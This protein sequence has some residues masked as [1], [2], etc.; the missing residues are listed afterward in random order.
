MPTQKYFKDIKT[1][2]CFL[3][4]TGLIHSTTDRFFA[5][6]IIKCCEPHKLYRAIHK[7][8]DR[9]NYREEI[10]WSNLN[11]KIRF[12]VACELF[13]IFLTESAIFNCIILDK[14]ELDF[15]THFNDDLCKAYRSFSV[16]LLK[17]IIGKNPQEVLIVL[18]D[19]YFTPDTVSLEETIK[20][21]VNDHYQNFVV[22]GVCQI[23]STSSDLLQLTDLILGALLYD[24]KRTRGLV[25]KQ[26][27][28]K[29]KFLNFLYQKLAVTNS[30]FLKDGQEI[31]NYHSSDN[32]VQATI[33][34][35][36]RSKAHN[37][38][39]AMTHNG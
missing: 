21:F 22:A 32:K 26:N 30:F 7:L 25:N 19:N 9:Y 10:K 35:S 37:K 3:D 34:D 29:R 12:K 27:N 18:A 2:F 17:L 4:E 13:N 36:E 15:K 6:G 39:Q 8:R 24:L 28:F 1:C 20:K 33:F 14:N 11:N 23:N 31:R 38:K 5:L 16:A